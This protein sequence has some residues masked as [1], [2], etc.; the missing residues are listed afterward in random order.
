MSDIS[1]GETLEL[2][3]CLGALRHTLHTLDRIGAGLA[4]IHV[5]AAI[6][7][8]TG[9]LE[10][11]ESDRSARFDPALICASPVKPSTH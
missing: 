6:E 1:T 11:I 7:Q 4:A 5:N 2:L 8:L 9:N 3:E 10:Q